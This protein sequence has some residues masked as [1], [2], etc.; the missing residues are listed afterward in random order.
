[1]F[2][3]FYV[4]ILL[5]ILFRSPQDD[6]FY[7]CAVVVA[8]RGAWSRLANYFTARSQKAAA[9][10]RTPILAPHSD[11][12]AA[13]YTILPPDGYRHEALGS[14]HGTQ[15]TGN[16]D[17]EQLDDFLSGEAG[18]E[19]AGVVLVFGKAT[20]EFFGQER[21]FAGGFYVEGTPGDHHPDQGA[22]FTDGDGGTKQRDENTRINWMTDA[23]IRTGAN[24][25]VTF[26][27]GD[28]AAPVCAEVI[29]RPDGNEDSRGSEQRAERLHRGNVWNKANGEP[30]VAKA[31]IVTEQERNGQSQWND[32][33]QAMAEGFALLGAFAF[34][35][36][37]E[38]I[39]SKDDPEAIDDPAGTHAH[40]RDNPEQGAD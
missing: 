21:F 11:D 5:A 39:E 27:Q 19:H 20:A 14:G 22:N 8:G 32:I 23:A 12:P 25:L 17:P 6:N 38:P 15:C 10:R 33:Q 3:A 35:S 2:T 30:G 34:E 26:F 13:H 28:G 29:T 37:E 1:M 36:G 24:Q 7:C 31:G 40:A 16:R 18:E 9:R 4:E